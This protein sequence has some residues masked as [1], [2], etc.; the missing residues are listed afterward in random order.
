MCFTSTLA[1]KQ[2]ATS[3]FLEGEKLLWAACHVTG[4]SAL[5]FG[6]AVG[7]QKRETHIWS[8]LEV[9]SPKNAFGMHLPYQ[10]LRAN[11]MLTEFTLSLKYNQ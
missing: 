11:D 9:L 2:A 5:I 7:V 3:Y 10:K 1:T 6:R 8:S 4:Y